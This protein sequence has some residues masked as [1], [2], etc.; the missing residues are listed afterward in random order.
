MAS[1]RGILNSFSPLTSPTFAGNPNPAPDA[2]PHFEQPPQLEPSG[3]GTTSW[4]DL[5][6]I[7]SDTEATSSI[8]SSH[9]RMRVCV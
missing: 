1:F 9:N 8:R 3:G 2:D 7:Q 6:V 5:T 4:L